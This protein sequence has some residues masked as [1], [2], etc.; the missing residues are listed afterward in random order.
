MNDFYL[1]A[2][3]ISI[4]KSDGFV[5]VKPYSDFRERYFKLSEVFID[6]FGAKRKFFVEKI[7]YRE[8]KLLIKFYNFNS[9]FDA[10]FLKGRS[11][12]VKKQ[13]LIE[14]PVNTFFVHDL[15][16]SRVF[17]NKLLFGELIDVLQL[18]SHFVFVIRDTQNREAMI[19]SSKDYVKSFDAKKKKLILRNDCDILYNDVK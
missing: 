12:F 9:P 4:Y 13:N 2:K 10:A 17:R 18:P 15:I 1:I 16:G 5:A 19:P 7:E 11:I 3:V 6:V 8:K 14:L